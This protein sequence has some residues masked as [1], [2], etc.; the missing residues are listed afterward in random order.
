MTQS[1]FKTV[2][3]SVSAAWI[4]SAAAL[5]ARAADA[6]PVPTGPQSDGPFRK[7][8]LDADHAMETGGPIEDTIVD[9]ME[10][11]VAKDGRVFWAERA[12]VV[13]MWSP[14]SKKTS[15][16]ASLKVFAGLEDGL[17][18]MTLDPRFPENNWLYLNRS[19]PDTLTDADGKKSG[20]IRVSRFTLKDEQLDPGSETTIIEVRTQREQCCHVGGSLG[21]DSA[22]NLF[23]SIGDNTN[24][25]ESDGYAPVD[26]RSGRSPWD[27]QKS[28]ANA[29]DLR[30]K[31][32]RITPKP[33]GGYSIPAGN[34]FPVGTPG[35]RPEIYAMG[36]RN[37][38]RVSI[39]PKT[40]TL[41][42]G[43]V[44]PDAGG[45]N[46]T[47]G[48]AG[49]DE[50]NQARKAGNFGWPYFVGENR[51][52]WHWDFTRKTN[53]FKFDPAKPV[54]H[55]PNNTGVAQLPPAQPAFISYPAG[56]SAKFPVLNA[57]G[58][59][60]AMAGPLYYFDAS[61]QSPHKLPKAFDR[62]LFIY[63]WSRNWI[64]AVH[65]DAQE[66]MERGPD[67]KPRMERICPNMTF[68]RPMDLELG[69]DGCLYLIEYG[70][71]WGNNKDTQIVRLEYHADAQASR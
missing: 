32:L 24:P 6:P 5:A 27:A 53:D 47:R 42:W 34:L 40:G 4:L 31:V 10:L 49:Y 38:F 16:I 61:L 70:T 65:L 11:S 56:P 69:P 39:D 71:A 25:F 26:E 44:G 14:Q 58:G 8:I 20:I 55:S 59:R 30:G 60:T 68:K 37:P 48:P 28:A 29:N 33:E 54:N 13:K 9:P 62:C 43:D 63:E 57:G 22:G 1:S 3:T 17:L 52:Y 41:Y 12:G 18:G 50:I 66:N 51:A 35:T 19:L 36:C 45:M 64:V 7:V 46:E 21:F 67:G 23:M 15:A 2:I